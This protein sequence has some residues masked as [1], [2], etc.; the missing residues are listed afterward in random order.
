MVLPYI[1]I[2]LYIQTTIKLTRHMH[3]DTISLCVNHS[4]GST[5]MQHADCRPSQSCTSKA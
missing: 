2:D 1:P 3:G 5:F 4:V